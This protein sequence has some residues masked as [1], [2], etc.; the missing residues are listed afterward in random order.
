MQLLTATMA[1]SGDVHC[2]RGCNDS[3]GSLEGSHCR[4]A[5]RIEDCTPA[6]GFP[7]NLANIVGHST[8]ISEIWSR[9][10]LKEK[11]LR[12]LG[13]QEVICKHV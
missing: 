11:L 7:C 5:R 10:R 1:N 13:L 8:E 3:A 6:M 4:S 9:G 12:D 2:G